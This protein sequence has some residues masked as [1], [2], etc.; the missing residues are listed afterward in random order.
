[1]SS[2]GRTLV[3]T[4]QVQPKGNAVVQ[5]NCITIGN[6]VWERIPGGSASYKCIRINGR[7]YAPLA[8]I[9]LQNGEMYRYNDGVIVGDLIV[10]KGCWVKC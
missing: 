7:P 2:F 6:T 1:M 8:G 5:N 4:L 9:L 10:K 3:N